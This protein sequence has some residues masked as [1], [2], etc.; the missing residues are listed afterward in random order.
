MELGRKGP[1]GPTLL[2]VTGSRNLA[3]QDFL[4]RE[5]VESTKLLAE[6]NAK[7][8]TMSLLCPSAPFSQA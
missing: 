5:S 3:S 6:V 4:M 7:K 8:G 1:L 2:I